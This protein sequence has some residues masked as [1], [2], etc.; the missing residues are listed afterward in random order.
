[1]APQAKAFGALFTGYLDAPADDEYSFFLTAD[2]GALLRVHEANVLD[3]DFG[4]RPSTE[5]T[6]TVRLQAGKHPIRS[7]CMTRD[8]SSVKHHWQW[9]R[10]GQPRQAIPA[11]ALPHDP[12]SGNPRQ[13][14]K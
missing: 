6:G 11:A 3:A 7:Y 2:S 13:E 10:P 14:P 1:V 5:V 9:S 4:H 12:T 8:A